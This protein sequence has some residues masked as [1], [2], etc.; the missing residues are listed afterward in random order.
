MNEA[1]RYVKAWGDRRARVLMIVVLASGACLSLFVWHRP[2]V[3]ALCLL[4]AALGIYGY[5]QFRCP[6][7]RERFMSFSRQ[8]IRPDG[9]CC[10]NCGLQKNALP[11]AESATG[12]TRRQG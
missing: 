6:R 1:D 7:C 2:W 9:A 4:G 5:F 3:A 11:P 12:A 10:Q 8:E